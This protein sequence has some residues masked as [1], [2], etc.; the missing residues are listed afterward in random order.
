MKGYRL[1]VMSGEGMCPH[2]CDAAEV[3][4]E[5]HRVG[6]DYRCLQEEIVPGWRAI[7][8]EEK[9]R[10][11]LQGGQGNEAAMGKG[12]GGGGGR[13][14]C[15]INWNILAPV[16]GNVTASSS[17]LGRKDAKDDARDEPAGCQAGWLAGR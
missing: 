9:L 10:D 11:D 8:P 14:F 12:G 1:K 13:G 3:D 7:P 6:E 17:C 4:V 15:Q 5:E 16:S 2:P